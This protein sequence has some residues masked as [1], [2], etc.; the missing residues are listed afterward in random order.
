MQAVFKLA[1]RQFTA[2]E[3][4]VIR[5]PFQ[6][7]AKGTQLDIKQ[8]LL[9]KNDENSLVGNPYVEGARIEAEVVDHGRDE[10]VTVYKFKRRT[11]YRRLRGHRQ[12]YSDL[13]IHRII[14]PTT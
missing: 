11:K 4:T 1:G 8:V 12:P 5:V 13:K 2:E 14:P 6:D 3:G 9:I 10:K 7:V